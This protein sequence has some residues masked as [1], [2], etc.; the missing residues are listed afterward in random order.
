MNAV[1][2][3]GNSILHFA[4]QNDQRSAVEVLLRY[5]ALPNIMNKAGLYAV[6][7]TK[8]PAVTELFQRDKHNIFSPVVVTRPAPSIEND[9]E[10]MS[11]KILGTDLLEDLNEAM[12]R[13]HVGYVSCAYTAL[14]SCDNL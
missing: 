2:E 12:G 11:A 4:T 7:M 14:L 1:D 3:A 9:P 6:E 8:N 13:V 5:G 10:L